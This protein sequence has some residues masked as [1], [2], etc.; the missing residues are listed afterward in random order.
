MDD[1]TQDPQGGG[2]ESMAGNMGRREY[3][4]RTDS[5]PYTDAQAGDLERSADDFRIAHKLSWA[6]LA[7]RLGVP[8][9]SL[10]EVR[11]AIKAGKPCKI[12]R[13]AVLRAIDE[14]LANEAARTGKLETSFAR[15]GA[16]ERVFGVSAAALRYCS[17]GVVIA[18]PGCGKTT[19]ARAI[20]ADRDGAVLVRVIEGRGTARGMSYL[21]AEAMGM[22]TDIT[23]PQR[24]AG[25]MSRLRVTRNCFIIIDECQKMDGSALECLRDLHDTSDP[26]GRRN[27]PMLLF[28]DSTFLR[29]ILR[30]RNGESSVVKPQLSRRLYPLLNFETDGSADGGKTLFTPEDIRRVLN[31]SRLKLVSEPGIQWLASLSNVPGYGALGLAVAVCRMALD[32]AKSTPIAPEELQ[33]ALKMLLGPRAVADVDRLAGGEL[34]RAVG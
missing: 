13:N 2:F 26:E 4:M 11:S 22:A 8:A 32:I 34:S 19:I 16:V 28:G 29:L 27:T 23:H 17:M 31:N 12:D 1:R 21:I 6:A 24:M 7:G 20:A 15:T 14:F 9:S 30:A 33:R 5:Q 3:R 18:P 25:I 10:S